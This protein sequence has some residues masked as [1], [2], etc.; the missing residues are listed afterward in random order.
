MTVVSWRMP[1]A[2]SVASISA[3]ERRFHVAGSSIAVR[4]EVDRS[5]KVVL[6]VLLGHAEVD[7]EKNEPVVVVLLGPAAGQQLAQPARVDEAIELGE[8]VDGERR[9]AGPC[10]EAGVVGVDVLVACG[11]EPGCQSGSCRPGAVAVEDD[12]PVRRDSLLEEKAVDLL[13]VDAVEP[14]GRERG[15]RPGYGRHAPRSPSRQPL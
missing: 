12:G 9:I 14:C 2:S 15:R 1:S 5:R 4:V 11:H 13:G 6:L 10:R 8:A 3:G 7:V